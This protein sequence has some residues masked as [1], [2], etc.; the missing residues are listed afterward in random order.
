MN[1]SFK[2]TPKKSKRMEIVSTEDV[3]ILQINI[4]KLLKKYLYTVLLYVIL[5]IFQQYIKYPIYARTHVHKISCK[6]IRT[7]I[8]TYIC[9]QGWMKLYLAMAS[10]TKH[11]SLKIIQR[12]KENLD[13]VTLCIQ[14]TS[15]TQSIS[16]NSTH[17]II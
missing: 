5:D 2:I 14:E 10:A 4:S 11:V 7:R 15:G 9:T 1:M 6:H 16:S 3:I 12:N 13:F 17:T 8:H